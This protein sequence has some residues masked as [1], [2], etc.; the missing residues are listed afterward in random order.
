MVAHMYTNQVLFDQSVPM[1]GIICHKSDKYLLCHMYEMKADLDDI[2]PKC[3]L[4][5]NS[6]GSYFT[7][8]S[9]LQDFLNESMQM[10]SIRWL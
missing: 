6:S 8:I 1:I 3:T 5:L 7:F 2:K 4:Y 10:S 9:V